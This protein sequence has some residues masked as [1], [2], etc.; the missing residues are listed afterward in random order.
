VT[1][2]GDR[3]FANGVL[4]A[5][6]A[7]GAVDEAFVAAHTT[8][9]AALRA[10]VEGQDWGLLERESGL[11]RS[12]MERF[13]ALYAAARSAVFVWSMGVTQHR[14]GVEN[15]GAIINLALARGMLGRPHC[16]L[17]PIRGH[18]GV[19][20]AAECGSVPNVLPG[21]EPLDDG[22]ARAR[23]EAAWGFPVPTAPGLMT[24]GMLDAAHAGQL[25]VLYL[26]GGNFLE[27]MPDPA[28]CRDA[29]GRVPLRIHQD[30]V[31]NSSTLVEGDAVLVLPAATRYE[32][33]GGGTS[34]TTERRV[35]FTPEIP[36]PRIAEARSEW[37]ILAAIG[38]RAVAPERRAA[39][40][41]VDAQG[42]RVEMERVM[43]LYRGIAGLRRAGDA[44]QYGGARLCEGGVCEGLP[45]GRAR[46]VSIPVAPTTRAP[47]ELVVTTRRGKQFNSMTQ[48]TTD[49]LTGTTGRDAVFM[50]AVDANRLGLV[51][52]APLELVSELGR[53]TG[54]CRLARVVPGT[55][56]VY[57]PEGNV[58]IGRRLDP[59]SGEPDYN[60]VVRIV[61]KPS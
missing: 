5:L 40:A 37:E 35:R 12:E 47:D 55:L 20:G 60:A 49:A 7:R 4:K 15:V 2:G 56:Q 36:G 32:Q 29:L 51:E 48:S 50:S 10:E 54:R 27:T 31:L 6:L 58:L 41:A 13:A 23:C 25:D 42:I 24:A 17:M 39:F 46:F 9:F 11:A 19:Q 45:D 59:A 8:G 52:G 57:W 26:L 3:A 30:I 33:R 14:D 38:A 34:T 61:T 18:S 16:G 22:A 43:P 53:F 28:W 44:I 1:I 21:G